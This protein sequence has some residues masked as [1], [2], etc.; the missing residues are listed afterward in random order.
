MIYGV[1]TNRASGL[2]YWAALENNTIIR[3]RYFM[4]ST[5]DHHRFLNADTILRMLNNAAP[6]EAEREAKHLNRCSPTTFD[7]AM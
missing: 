7:S 5:G 2:R 6:G 3:A 1:V 4:P